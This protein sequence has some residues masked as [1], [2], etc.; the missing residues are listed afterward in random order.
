[1]VKRMLYLLF[2]VFAAIGAVFA[3]K[4]LPPDNRAL[5]AEKYSGW[6]GVLRVHVFDV[7]DESGLTAWLNACAAKFEKAHN[8]VYVQITQADDI[9][10]V[11]QPGLRVPDAVLF[12]PGALEHADGLV[13]LTEPLPVRESLH[14]SYYAVPVAAGGYAWAV[15]E[16]GEVIALPADDSLHSWSAA[17]LALSTGEAESLPEEIELPGID[18]GLPAIAQGAPSYIEESETP[19]SDFVSGRAKA[20]PVTAREIA[21]LKSLSDQGR[22]PEWTIDALSEFTFTDQ[23]ALFAVPDCPDADAAERRALTVE[24]L[25]CLLSEECQTNLTKRNAFPVTD[26][27]AQYAASDPMAA[28]DRILRTE[29]V[30]TPP[31]FGNEWRRDARS[32]LAEYTSGERSAEEAFRRLFGF[33]EES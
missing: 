19:F 17:A 15:Q 8:G 33:S 30:V 20:M 11:R 28:I 2:A 18:L 16:E 24:F 31:V 13:P 6:S 12:S 29:S 7:F 5:V 9:H 23:L 4:M 14:T 22:G 1:M 3:V 26:A 27:P 25:H 21:R 10:A 32:A